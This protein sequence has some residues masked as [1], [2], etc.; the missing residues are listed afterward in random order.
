MKNPDRSV[1]KLGV[2]GGIGSG[3]STVCKVF[4][5]LGIPVFSAD[6]EARV[7]MD[8]DK[9]VKK[10]I[11]ELT[12]RDMYSSGLLDRNYLA[13]MIFNDKVLLNNVNSVVHPAVFEKFRIWSGEQSSPYVIM[14]AAILFE[15]GASKLVD[16]VLTIVTPLEERIERLIK[17]NRL[18]R[19][20]IMERIHNQIDD[21][22]R[23]RNSDYVIFNS[24]NDLILPA[25]IRVHNEIMENVGKTV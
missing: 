20:Q 21:D 5:I 22:S 1:F 15:S 24:E 13:R 6:S 11:N 16:R 14:E 2:T 12:G 17:G 18:T 23:I 4:N 8:N 25:I 3:K 9:S 19:E 7:I 10:K